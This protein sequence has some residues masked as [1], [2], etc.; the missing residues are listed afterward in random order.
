MQEKL[1]KIKFWF[2]REIKAQINFYG[3]LVLAVLGLF[4]LL[5]NIP[6]AIITLSVIYCLSIIDKHEKTELAYRQVQ[7]VLADLLRMQEAQVLIMA[8]ALVV[9]SAGEGVLQAIEN[10]TAMEP[11]EEPELPVDIPPRVFH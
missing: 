11:S 6:A 7:G 1:K 5:G 2:S 4:C 9:R 8:Q 3:F 10:M